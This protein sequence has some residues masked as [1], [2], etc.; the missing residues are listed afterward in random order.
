MGNR[1]STLPLEDITH[2]QE[3]THCTSINHPHIFTVSAVEIK[4]LYARFQKLDKDHSGSLSAEEL[5][6]I[7]EFAMNPLAHRLLPFFLSFDDVTGAS[8]GLKGSGIYSRTGTPALSQESLANDAI[9]KELTFPGFIRILSHFHPMASRGEKLDRIDFWFHTF[10]VAFRIYNIS[11]DGLLKPEEV[12]SILKSM[13]GTHLN[14]E[15]IQCIVDKTIEKVDRNGDGCI[16]L[17]EFEAV[18]S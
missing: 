7:P 15:E 13:I 5:M 11:G 12:F 14:D 3:Q 16:D 4:N 6:A 17:E 1:L 10:V 8:D 18:I 9:A 2:L